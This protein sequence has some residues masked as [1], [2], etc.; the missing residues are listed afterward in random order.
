M[1]SG[2]VVP[3]RQSL[4]VGALSFLQFDIGELA[5]RQILL[6]GRLPKRVFTPALDLV[7]TA[8]YQRGTGEPIPRSA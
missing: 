7:T 5:F 8:R 1:G 2:Q 4:R 6:Q 3:R